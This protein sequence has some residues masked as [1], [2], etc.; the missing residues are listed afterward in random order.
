MDISRHHYSPNT[1]GTCRP[2]LVSLLGLEMEHWESQARSCGVA[3]SGLFEKPNR[4]RARACLPG[5]L[6]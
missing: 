1:G 5:M 4:D 3:G 2:P 6:R